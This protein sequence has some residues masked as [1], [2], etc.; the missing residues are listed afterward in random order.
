MVSHLPK[1]AVVFSVQTSG[2]LLYYTNF[3][4]VRWETLSPAEFER[5]AAACSAAGLPVFA[6]LHRLEV[7]EHRAFQK[8]LTGHWT[9]LA[10]VRDMSIWH[11]DSPEATP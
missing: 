2:C 1:N 6:S 9:Q 4:V 3:T 10:L 8:H 11:Y 5:I 7:E